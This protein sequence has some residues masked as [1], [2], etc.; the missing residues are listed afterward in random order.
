MSSTQQPRKQPGLASIHK[1]RQDRVRGKF[2]RP[3]GS[4]FGYVGL[5]VLASLL[6]Y[7]FFSGRE[8]D[9]ARSKLLAKQRAAEHELGSRW[10]P[11]RDRIESATLDAAKAF[12]GDHVDSDAIYWDFRNQPGLYLR[13]RTADAT[14]AESLRKAASESS[15][16]GFTGCLLREP[17]AEAARGEPDAGAFA[18]QPWNMRQAYAATRILTPQWVSEV[19]EAT[20]EL[21]LRV[22]AQQY[23][24]A[25]GTEIPLAADIV[26]RAKFFLLVLDED[27]DEARDSDA[28]GIITEEGL[29]LVAHPSRVHLLNLRSGREVMRLRRVGEASFVFAGEHHAVDDETR[30]A[31][32]RQV[33]NCSLARQVEEALAPARSTERRDAGG[34]AH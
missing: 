14:D 21:R 9:G 18:E 22:F 33:N 31:M 6:A 24:K 2:S 17:N 19:K 16:D 8:I 11:I 3:T 34:S 29:Q 23:E 15:K 10:F 25:I 32:Q 12:Q 26:T 5:A 20:D 13:L 1:A 27:V 4:T 30:R 28:G 7:R